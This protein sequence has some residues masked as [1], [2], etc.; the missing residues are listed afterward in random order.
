MPEAWPVLH[1]DDPGVRVRSWYH[2]GTLGSARPADVRRITLADHVA[3]ALAVLDD[4][5]IDRAVLM[6]WSVGVTT[7]VELAR[8]HPD[9]V[10]GLLL[11]AGPPGDVFGGL[12]GVLG[13]PLP[14]RRRLAVEASR[15]LQAG[16]PLVNA[17][18]HRFPVTALTA[19]LAR[20]SGFLRPAG[21]VGEVIAAGRRFLTN[22]WGWYGRLA[23]AFAEVG[24][25]DLTGL[26]LPVTV[27]TGRYDVIAD[28]GH[29][30][31]PFA[32]L[33]QA[34]IR[35]LPTSHFLALEAPDELLAELT[36]LTARAAAVD[37][38]R[39]RHTPAG[40]ALTGRSRRDA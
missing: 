9:R 1:R 7:A 35:V 31:A 3:D 19:N 33:P 2:R 6:G 40:T 13:L 12:F 14:V 26:T 28:P 25:Q 8:R 29:A 11:V 10:A 24:P 17:V 32:V 5:G 22:D 4:A 34:R 16:G 15:W 39:H 38:A 27:L 18:L 21:P 23:R 30:G 37:T 20:Y 36:L